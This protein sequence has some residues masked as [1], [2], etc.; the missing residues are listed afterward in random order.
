MLAVPGTAHHLI[1]RQAMRV[2]RETIDMGSVHALFGEPEKGVRVLE[3]E[4]LVINNQMLAF[5]YV[6][7]HACWTG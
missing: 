7:C 3:K 6:C 1:N 4:T 2:A 5:A